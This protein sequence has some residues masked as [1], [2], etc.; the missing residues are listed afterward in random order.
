MKW[1]LGS[2]FS[3][4]KDAFQGWQ[5]DDATVWCAAVAYFTIFSIGP[6]LLIIISI[7]GLIF[8]K[9]TIEKNV[10]DQIQG[11]LGSGGAGILETV[12]QHAKKPST[13]IIGTIVGTITLILGATGVFGQLQQMLNTIWGVKQKPKA[14]MM[15]FVTNRILNISMIGVIAFLLLVSLI[16]S[17]AISGIG[18]FVGQILPISPIILEISNFVIS[19][20]IVTILFAFIMKVL[21]DVEIKWKNIWIGAIITS[22]LFTIGKSIIGI[23]IGHSGISSEYG[24]AASLIVLLL[25]V[26]YSSQI[27]FFGVELTKAYTLSHGDKILPSKYAILIAGKYPPEQEKNNLSKGSRTAAKL[28][29][30]FTEGAIDTVVKKANSKKKRK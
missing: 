21:P 6:L 4:L 29:R 16:A 7:I 12:I 15:G 25:W 22:L 5:K 24:A 18:T 14:G 30:G 2:F 10:F 20:V 13:G 27:L 26:Y 8:S 28:A 23:Y 11:L 1:S 3:L 9:T 17:T 19:F